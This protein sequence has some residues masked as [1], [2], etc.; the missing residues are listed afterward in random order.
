M[1][2]AETDVVSMIEAAQVAEQEDLQKMKAELSEAMKKKVVGQSHPLTYR[3]GW[4]TERIIQAE[5]KISLLGAILG[6]LAQDKKK[7]IPVV[8][9]MR[10]LKKKFTN[11]IV[12]FP[13][14]H[15]SSS[16]LSNLIQANEIRAK[17][18]I[19]GGDIFAAG[20]SLTGWIV[21]LEQHQPE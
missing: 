20:D 18:E 9:S 2:K 1:T 17:A 4:D 8:E 12:S 6:Q 7:N 19:I 5:T 14:Y 13:Y 10:S 21:Y 11:N 15:N 16:S 3:L